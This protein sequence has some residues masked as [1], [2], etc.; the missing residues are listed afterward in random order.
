[1]S[2]QVI[3]KVSETSPM[4]TLATVETI[5]SDALEIPEDNPMTAEKVALGKA[6]YFD[7]R[8]SKDATLST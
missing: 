1:M 2:Q 6:L 3:A 4:R 7:T 5:S 8:L